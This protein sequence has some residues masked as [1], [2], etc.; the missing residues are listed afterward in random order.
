[1]SNCVKKLQEEF[2]QQMCVTTSQHIK[3]SRVRYVEYP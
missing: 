1:M 2:M 3:G